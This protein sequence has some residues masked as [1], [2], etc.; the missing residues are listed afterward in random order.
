[1]QTWVR[2]HT[3]P[4]DQSSLSPFSSLS[5]PLFLS[6]P[7][8]CG[9]KRGSWIFEQHRM[10]SCLS[11]YGE[12]SHRLEGNVPAPVPPKIPAPPLPFL[13][14][15]LWSLRLVLFTQVQ[16]ECRHN[17]H[18]LSLFSSGFLNFFVWKRRFFSYRVW[19]QG[20]STEGFV[21]HDLFKTIVLFLY[22]CCK[23]TSFTA[24]TKAWIININ[25][26][27]R[28]SF[29]LIGVHTSSE[30]CW[31]ENSNILLREKNS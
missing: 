1:M 16:Y 30:K 17:E 31:S 23:S 28:F 7:G 15:F 2:L 5:R 21:R 13:L 9:K 26:N 25:I 8:Q 14:F 11:V 20:L 10:D 22:V 12:T 6:C 27:S 4:A 29:S 24:L 3:G 18:H 19:S